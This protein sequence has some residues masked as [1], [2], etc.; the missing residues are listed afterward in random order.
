MDPNFEE[1][2]VHRFEALCAQVVADTKSPAEDHGGSGEE[3]DKLVR[4]WVGEVSRLLNFAAVWAKDYPEDFK[5]SHPSISRMVELTRQWQIAVSHIDKKQIIL[6]ARLVLRLEAYTAVFGTG[7]GGAGTAAAAAAAA[8]AAGPAAQFVSP[9]G[10]HMRF[11]ASGRRQSLRMLIKQQQQQEA[12]GQ[13]CTPTNPSLSV[14]VCVWWM[15][16]LL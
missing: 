10:A 11:A 13:T 7:G 3:R 8:A 12:V 15:M 2:H 14:C 5:P 16:I 9:A 1:T 4:S 6:A